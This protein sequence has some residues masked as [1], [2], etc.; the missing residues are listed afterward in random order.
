MPQY[1][2]PKTVLIY[3]PHPV[4]VFFITGKILIEIDYENL[5]I[6]C[7]H[8]NGKWLRIVLQVLAFLQAMVIF[9]SRQK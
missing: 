8:V 3:R 2:D 7:G 6:R 4:I 9:T 5:K 1:L